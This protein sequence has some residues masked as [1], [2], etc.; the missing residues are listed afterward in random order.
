MCLPTPRGTSTLLDNLGSRAEVATTAKFS[1]RH[2]LQYS[3][4]W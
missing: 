2:A 1:W 3:Q 4:L